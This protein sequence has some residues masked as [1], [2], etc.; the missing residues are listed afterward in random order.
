MRK[1]SSGSMGCRWN[2]GLV[3]FVLS[4]VLTLP[5]FSQTRKNAPAGDTARPSILQM[6]GSYLTPGN[7][8]LALRDRTTRHYEVDAHT[9]VAVISSSPVFYPSRGGGLEEI[10]DRIIPDLK[11]EEEGFRFRNEANDILFYFS[12]D[13]A[14]CAIGDGVGNDVGL[15]TSPYGSGDGAVSVSG[16]QL[17]KIFD[18]DSSVLLW[19]VQGSAVSYRYFTPRGLKMADLAPAAE[20]EWLSPVTELE[21]VEDERPNYRLSASTFACPGAP[22]GELRL[23][24]MAA[25]TDTTATVMGYVTVGAAMTGSVLKASPGGSP[26]ASGTGIRVQNFSDPGCSYGYRGWA[27]YDLSTFNPSD[28]I[29]LVEQDIY[30]NSLVSYWWD[31]VDVNVTRLTTDPMAVSAPTTWADIG[32]GVAYVY[33]RGVYSDGW[34]KWF[35]PGAEYDFARAITSPGWFGLGFM[36]WC[37]ENNADFYVSFN[38]VEGGNRPYLYI[39]YSPTT[40]VEEGEGTPESYALF[41]NYPN[42]FNPTTAISYALPERSAVVLKVY[43]MIGEVVSTLVEEVQDPGRRTVEWIAAGGFATGPYICRLTA[44]SESD[45]RRVFVENRK[46]LLVK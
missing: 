17:M 6:Y 39:M 10:S 25:R 28:T 3:P 9:R 31:L 4:V 19:T 33:D 26:V 38:G 15:I 2:A 1:Y 5:G 7:E 23:G 14:S 11:R 22:G 30:V 16:N 37:D 44:V 13:G 27:K 43:N 36:V 32:A 40:D 41:Q 45:P 24:E 34:Q 46:M 35:L 29:I 8:L 42:P 18:R 20:V 21:H 12:P